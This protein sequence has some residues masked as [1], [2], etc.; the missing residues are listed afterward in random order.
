[1]DPM[2]EGKGEPGPDKNARV[3]VRAWTRERVSTPSKLLRIAI[4]GFFFA[5]NDAL[6]T[7]SAM[8]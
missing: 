2:D 3:R 6:T 8:L 1:M 7:S 5:Q 4:S